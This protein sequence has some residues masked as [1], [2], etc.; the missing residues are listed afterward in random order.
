MK[1]IIFIHGANSSPVSFNF[2]SH[3]LP[4]HKRVDFSY[5]TNDT[6][7][8]SL[9]KL[10][11]CI[12]N[13]HKSS[14]EKVCL[15]AHSMGGILA[16]AAR[17]LPTD[18]VGS[19]CTIASPVM[20]IKS[21]GYLRFAFPGEQIFNNVAPSNGVIRSIREYTPALPTLACITTKGASPFFREP[22]DGVV[23]VSS[24]EGPESI[25]RIY[26]PLNH[27]EVLLDYGV[28]DTVKSFL[29]PGLNED[30][31]A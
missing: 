18:G 17:Q 28:V 27:F 21:A 2:L 3:F 24:Q 26:F 12:F 29:F 14:L 9:L 13:E 8:Y 7:E 1:T 30:K 15:V 31:E 16:L 20:G 10:D 4:S 25:P 23:T 5:E 19:I 11:T 6:L 22:N